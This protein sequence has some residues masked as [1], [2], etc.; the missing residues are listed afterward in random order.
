MDKVKGLAIQLDILK[1]QTYAKAV[2]LG[3]IV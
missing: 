1:E 2:I 3:L